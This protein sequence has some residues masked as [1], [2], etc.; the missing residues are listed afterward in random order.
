MLEVNEALTRKVADLARLELSDQE[1]TSFTK[2]LGNILSYVEQ[3]KEVDVTGVTPMTHPHDVETPMRED[4]VRP[5]LTDPQGHP[6][7]LQSAPDVMYD[8]FKVPPIL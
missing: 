4:V 7:V 2:Q 1:V 3:L 8:G 5:S 6:R